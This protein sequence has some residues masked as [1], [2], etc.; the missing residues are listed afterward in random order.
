VGP[1]QGLLRSTLDKT[2]DI[3]PTKTPATIELDSFNL[4]TG[5]VPH[6]RASTHA[7]ISLDPWSIG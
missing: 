1:L 4:P 3:F 2:L 7:K 5:N 6:E